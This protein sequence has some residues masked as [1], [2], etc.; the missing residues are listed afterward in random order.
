MTAEERIQLLKDAIRIE[1]EFCI[2]RARLYMEAHKETTELPPALRRAKIMEKIMTE[3]SALIYDEEL[4]VGNPTSKRVA[5]PILAE[6]AWK[7]YIEK[8]PNSPPGDLIDVEGGLTDDEKIQFREILK[9]WDGK[10]L[11]DQWLAVVPQ[12]YRELENLAWMQSS[13]NPSAGYYLAHCI[14]DYEKVLKKG[15]RGILEEIDER[16]EELDPIQLNNMEAIIFL[17]AMKISLNSVIVWAQH[18]SE[19]AARQAKECA[20]PQRKAELEKIAYICSKVPAE[21]AETFYEALQSVW[22]IY[23]A[24]MQ[25]SWGPGVGFG[26]M[27]QYL[28]PY[29]RKDIDSGEITQEQVKELIAMLYLKLNELVNPFPVGK[30]TAGTL[31]GITIGGESRDGT[32]ATE[33][34]AMMFLE[35]E[36]M[37]SMIED[38]VV[39]IHHS[40]SDAFLYRACQLA[41]SVRGKVK[42]L[43]DETVYKQQM[44]MGRTYAMAREYAAT[45]CFIHTI[46]GKTHDP[47]SDAQNLPMMLELALNNGFTRLFHKKIGAETGDPRN[48]KSYEELWEAYKTQVATVVPQS[49][50]GVSYFQQL[51]ATYFPS[52]MMSALFDGCIER[53]RDVVNGGTAPYSSVGLW[54]TGTV[55]VGDSLAAV[56]KVVFDDKKITMAQLID[57]LDNNFEGAEDILYLLKKAPKFGNDID[58]VDNIVNDVICN[59]ADELEKIKGHAGRKFMMA[60]ATIGYNQAFGFFLGASPD[61]RR[62]HEALGEGG[63]SPH[64]GRNTSGAT[65]TTRSVAKLNLVRSAGGNVLNMKFDPSSVDTPVKMMNFVNFLRTFASTGGDVIQ[66]N[67]V[68]NEMLLDA[69]KH[70]EKYRDLLVRVAT[71]S[72]YFVDLDPMAQQEIIDRTSFGGF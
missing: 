24:I 70:P 41:T 29:Y 66:F 12:E 6:I 48:F 44:N 53:G 42:F 5:A 58:Y 43:C 22:I 59:L 47:G 50:I 72:A 33:E 4:L 45:G 20:D 13:G 69:Q 3:R 27:D 37:V 64:Q 56:K 28:Y 54:V 7:W 51:W 9:Y 10:C 63:I 1:P 38:L 60:A 25:E 21:P 52:P 36:D 55:N 19:E 30:S 14:P 16:L 31:S 35:A 15:I 65:A 2:E 67:M 49:L 8:E 26:R 11:R 23:I 57:A 18:L 46:P 34:L 68:S 32:Q 40:C 71:Y 61:G 39:R 62:A 17:K